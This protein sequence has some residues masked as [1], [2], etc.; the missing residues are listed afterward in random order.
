M[1]DSS[2]YSTVLDHPVDQVWDVVRDFNSYPIWVNGVDESHIEGDLPGTA[3]GCVRDFSM[4][5]SRTRQR[6]LA[7]SDVD[8]LFTYESCTPLQTES[9][10]AART[11]W[12]YEGTL[13]LRPITDG[14][15]SYA[16][17]SATYECPPQDAEYWS[18]WWQQSL[19]AWLAS[20]RTHLDGT[21]RR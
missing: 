14:Q 1:S 10:G 20:L 4:G 11:L 5:A 7:H 16:E 15:R 9:D 12:H 17:W 18:T 19:P 13:Q 8:R 3:V 6:L 21:P 2:S